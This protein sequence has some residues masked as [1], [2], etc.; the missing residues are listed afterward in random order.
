MPPVLV[1][2]CRDCA[3]SLLPVGIITD[4]IIKIESLIDIN[5]ATCMG[6]YGIDKAGYK[7]SRPATM[8]VAVRLSQSNEWKTQVSARSVTFR[9]NLTIGLTF[10]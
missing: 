6:A 1:I 5:K 9:P 2:H 7:K 4:E 10:A 8:E 3:D